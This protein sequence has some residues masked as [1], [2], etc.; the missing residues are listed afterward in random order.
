M[1]EVTDRES[2]REEPK[3]FPKFLISFQCK[4]RL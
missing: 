2:T 1:E 3:D 4:G